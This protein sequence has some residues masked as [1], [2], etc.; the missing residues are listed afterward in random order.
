MRFREAELAHG[1][2]AMIAGL[3]FLVQE[4][5][6]APHPPSADHSPLPDRT[7]LTRRACVR[8]SSILPALTLRVCSRACACVCSHPIFPEISGPGAKQLDLVLQTE[9]GQA[10]GATLL[11]GIWLTEIARARIGWKDPDDGFQELRAEYTPGD[12][13]FDPLGM[14]A[15]MDEAEMLNMRNKELNNGRL[16]MIAVAG[17]TAEEL[18]SGAKLFA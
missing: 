11:F 12:L 8:E 3:G 7:H 13:G 4:N 1:R 2:V 15:K 10:V 17:M 9:N 16:A 5:L 6:C 18:A 14:T